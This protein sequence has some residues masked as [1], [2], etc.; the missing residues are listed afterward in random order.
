MIST[1]QTVLLCAG[2]ML[3]SS[4]VCPPTAVTLDAVQNAPVPTLIV[5][6]PRPSVNETKLEKVPDAGHPF[7]PPGLKDQRGPCPALNTLANHGYLPH[8]GVVHLEQIINATR[9]GFN[10]DYDL[11]AFLGSF[12][13]LARGNP[14]YNLLS[15]GGEDEQVPSLP[16]KVDGKCPRGGLAKHGRFEGDVSMTREDAELGDDRNFQ[17]NLYD[18]FLTFIGKYG[19]DSK[20]TGP[21]S[22]VNLQVMK[23]FKYQRFVDE[24]MRNPKLSFHASRLASSYNEAAFILKFFANGTDETLTVSSLGSIFRNQSFAPNWWR[25]ASPGDL[26]LIASTASDINPP[27]TPFFVKPG[28]NKDG[29][30]VEDDMSDYKCDTGYYDF[31]YHNLPHTYDEISRGSDILGRNVKLLLENIARPF[32]CGT[33]KVVPNGPIDPDGKCERSD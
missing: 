27:N 14:E 7:V 17:D 21:N 22:L 11:A 32:N 6:P 26:N 31:V 25:R 9:E 15:I 16:V 10:M 23:H 5:M 3:S 18:Q 28:E 4:L 8:T 2:S 33:Y 20:V 29:K 24:Q 19:D 12:L 1:M 13:M 30:Y